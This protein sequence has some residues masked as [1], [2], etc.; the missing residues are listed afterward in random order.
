MASTQIRAAEILLNRTVPTLTSTQLTGA[1]GGAV[2]IRQKIEI[3]FIGSD[4]HP[5]PKGL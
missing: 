2:K 5:D 3:E 1:D 4:A